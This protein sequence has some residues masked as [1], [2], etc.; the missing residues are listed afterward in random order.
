LFA[1]LKTTAAIH[2]EFSRK[3][4]AMKQQTRQTRVI[5]TAISLLAFSGVLNV[6][7]QALEEVVITAQKRTESLQDVPVSVSALSTADLEGLKLRDSGEIAAQIPNLQMINTAGDGFPIFSLRGVAMSDYSFNQSSPVAS[8]VDEV[9]KGNP[10]IQGVQ[11]FDLE[12][13]EVLRGPQG[14]LYGKNSTG[15]AV[16]F[17]TKM[18]SFD[19]SGYIRIGAGDYDRKEAHGAFETPL[20]DD[21]LA[22]RLA[23]TWIEQNG[24]FE[25]KLAGIDDG[26][27]VDEYGLRASVLWQPNDDLQL[28]LRASTGEQN[29]CSCAPA[30]PCS[31]RK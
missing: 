3:L 29:A 15:G 8:Y 6:N 13:I 4:E 24:W 21:V 11:V 5:S 12:R 28:I 17:I 9:Y 10:A 27:A 23:G 25:N 1:F 7:A 16:N 18:P 2:N 19:R 30:S 14:T 26:N 31:I 22:I 20:I